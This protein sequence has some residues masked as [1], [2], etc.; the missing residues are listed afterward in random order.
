METYLM[1]EN[2]LWYAMGGV[3]LIGILILF[4]KWF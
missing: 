1:I 4:Q 2:G 3:G